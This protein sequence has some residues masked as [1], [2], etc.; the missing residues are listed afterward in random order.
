MVLH[1]CYSITVSF[2]IINS[3]FFSLNLATDD[4]S[5]VGFQEICELAENIFFGGKNEFRNET[6]SLKAII[7]SEKSVWLVLQ[8]LYFSFKLFTCLDS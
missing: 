4:F 6:H 7:Y 8:I 3:Q 2:P 5:F 1:V